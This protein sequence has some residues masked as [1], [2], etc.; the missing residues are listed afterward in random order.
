M[1]R[2]TLCRSRLACSQSSC[3]AGELRGELRSAAA[4]ETA[5]PVPA[6]RQYFV[7]TNAKTE[8]VCQSDPLSHH[9]FGH[10]LRKEIRC[11]QLRVLAPHTP[12]RELQP[13]HVTWLRDSWLAAL[14]PPH[15]PL[16]V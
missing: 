13:A 15:N 2:A 5:F 7:R 3:R 10:D 12:V 8:L 4:I 16:A 6:L 11:K 1:H 9:Q 14:A